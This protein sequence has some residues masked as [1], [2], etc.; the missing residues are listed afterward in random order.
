MASVS[1]VMKEGDDNDHRKVSNEGDESPSLVSVI[2]SAKHS[3]D[4]PTEADSFASAMSGHVTKSSAAM[5]V[6]CLVS[7]IA[8]AGYG[9]TYPSLKYLCTTSRSEATLA[10]AFTAF[11]IG[12]LFGSAAIGI[13]SGVNRYDPA[14]ALSLAL[15]IVGT[16]SL[17]NAPAL[18]GAMGLYVAQFITGLGAGICVVVARVYVVGRMK[19]SPS[20]HGGEGHHHKLSTTT[21][22]TDLLA[23]LIAAQYA[24]M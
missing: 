12:R 17:A 5:L 18:G 20:R 23:Q 9:M 11:C 4:L 6:V 16:L 15:V 10:H 13:A 14:L 3:N 1:D 7:F 21:A 2:D 24:G 19:V 8:E 22:R